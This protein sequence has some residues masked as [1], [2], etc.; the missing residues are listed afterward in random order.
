MGSSRNKTGTRKTI[1]DAIVEDIRCDRGMLQA[2][3]V[4][5]D[6][7]EWAKQRGSYERQ[8]AGIQ[9][10][11]KELDDQF[12]QAPAMIAQYER[13]IADKTGKLREEQNRK[14]V[15]QLKSTTA[16]VAELMADPE[17][18]EMLR[19]LMEAERAAAGE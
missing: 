18:L 3:R 1:V 2:W 5:G 13:R 8:V 12:E 16:K 4:R 19:K 17:A 10:K 15:E 6:A 14:Q 7:D 9:L 11:M